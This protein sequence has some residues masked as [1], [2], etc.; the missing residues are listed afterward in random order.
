[1]NNSKL[2]C[3]TNLRKCVN[4]IENRDI[5]NTLSPSCTTIHL[6]QLPV[7]IWFPKDSRIVTQNRVL[8]HSP[9]CNLIESLGWVSTLKESKINICCIHVG[10]T[11]LLPCLISL[12]T[13]SV[14]WYSFILFYKAALWLY[15][16]RKTVQI[17][18]VN[19]TDGNMKANF[20][21]S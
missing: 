6:A 1:M 10:F 21:S 2:R 12:P 11:S 17:T 20:R 14:T 4:C 18:K 8:L 9:N 5:I 16:Y 13:L 3:M 19:L 15:S 7:R